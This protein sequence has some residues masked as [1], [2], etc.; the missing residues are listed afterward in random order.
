MSKQEGYA[1][2]ITQILM[3]HI[4][5]WPLTARILRHAGY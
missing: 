5:S 3:V 1:L 4:S 2:L